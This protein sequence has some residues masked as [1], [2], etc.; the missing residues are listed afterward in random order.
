MLNLNSLSKFNFFVNENTTRIAFYHATGVK[1][2]SKKVEIN[3][4]QVKKFAKETNLPTTSTS[5]GRARLIASDRR[6][7]ISAINTTDADLY[8]GS[9]VK[10]TMAISVDVASFENQTVGVVYIKD[11]SKKFVTKFYIGFDKVDIT[12]NNNV[13]FSGKYVKTH[14]DLTSSLSYAQ[15]RRVSRA[16]KM[17]AQLHSATY[18][19]ASDIIENIYTLEGYRAAKK[20]IEFSNVMQAAIDMVD[21]KLAEDKTAKFEEVIPTEEMV[22]FTNSVDLMEI[23]MGNYESIGQKIAKQ[24]YDISGLNIVSCVESN[25]TIE[26]EVE[27]VK[28]IQ[29]HYQAVLPCTIKEEEMQAKEFKRDRSSIAMFLADETGTDVNVIRDRLNTVMAEAVNKRA[30]GDSYYMDAL[31]TVCMDYINYEFNPEYFH[32]FTDKI[33]SVRQNMKRDSLGNATKWE[34]KRPH[35]NRDSQLGTP[36]HVMTEEEWLDNIAA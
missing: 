28:A 35:V 7:V 31:N 6:K 3:L 12:D 5:E 20:F 9:L 33:I 11:T 18:M 32:E 8:T 17:D 14:K 1:G 15:T 2:S 19:A 29:S 34:E 13:Q 23:E 21:A 16:N 10:G 27:P 22:E 25:L 24:R 36:N 26:D 4:N 30:E